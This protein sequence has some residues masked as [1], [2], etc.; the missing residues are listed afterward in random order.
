[1][2]LMGVLDMAGR[3]AVFT[4]LAAGIVGVAAKLLLMRQGTS[5]Q[6]RQDRIADL[7]SDG[8]MPD[9]VYHDRL[10]AIQYGVV[11]PA[12][13]TGLGTPFYVADHGDHLDR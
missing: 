3:V 12:D 4:V 7:C 10:T 11:H 5:L 9:A 6:P 2:E 1:M 8:P 13:L